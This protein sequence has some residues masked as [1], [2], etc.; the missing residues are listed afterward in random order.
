MK[1]CF[2]FT[3]LSVSASAIWF[4]WRQ[5]CLLNRSTLLRC[6]PAWVIVVPLNECRLIYSLLGEVIKAVLWSSEMKAK[7][8]T[9][10]VPTLLEIILPF[11]EDLSI[12]LSLFLLTFVQEVLKSDAL[13]QCVRAPSMK[14]AVTTASLWQSVSAVDVCVCMFLMCFPLFHS[15]PSW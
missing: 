7:Q 10:I 4:A 9:W 15:L 8:F 5:L 6:L 11:R 12:F 14:S 13:M 3:S 1:F 2:L